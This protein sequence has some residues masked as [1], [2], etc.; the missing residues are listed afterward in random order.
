MNVKRDSTVNGSGL[1]ASLESRP[2]PSESSSRPMSR[3]S[4]DDFPGRFVRSTRNCFSFFFFL[5]FRVRLH[6]ISVAY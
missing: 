1:R 4:F 2:P 3:S 6:R 5:G